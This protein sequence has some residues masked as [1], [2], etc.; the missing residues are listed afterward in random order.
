[1]YQQ[2]SDARGAHIQNQYD[3]AG[4]AQRERR[5]VEAV[6]DNNAL[7]A[8]PPAAP[9]GAMTGGVPGYNYADF[10]DATARQGHDPSLNE[11]NLRQRM[12]YPPAGG[13]PV[14]QYGGAMDAVGGY[15]TGAQANPMIGVRGLTPEEA[16][17]PLAMMP[18]DAQGNRR[19]FT[20]SDSNRGFFGPNPLQRIGHFLGFGN[21][22]PI[23]VD[24]Y[25]HGYTVGSYPR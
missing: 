2:G 5:F 8:A 11:A 4:Q 10:D 19:P 9:P 14:P 16:A 12:G 25:S 23:M 13:V 22:Q 1:M 17:N 24:P 15:L 20:A 18:V 3:A 7:N 21:G 6:D